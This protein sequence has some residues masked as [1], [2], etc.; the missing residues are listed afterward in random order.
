V[1]T[2][3][4]KNP[5]GS[6]QEQD[7]AS[8][9]TIGR[10]DGNDLILSEGG[11]S[12]KH[13][14]FFL[15]GEDMLVED[16]G[17]ANG[18]WVDGEKIE[19]PTKLS[20]KSQ[21]VI[22]DYEIQLKLGS[23]PLPK[24]S[25]TGARPS[26]EPTAA[27]G[28]ALKPAAPRSTRVV[29]AMKGGAG[30]GGAALAKRPAPQRA[31][32]P[33]L[34]GL[35]GALTGKSFPLSGTLTVG[36]VAGVDLQVE[37]DSVSRR[38]AELE[39]KGREVIVRDLGSA[40]GTSVNGAAI[41]AETVLASG[42]IVQFG[43]VEFMFETGTPSGA[44]APVARP[45]R[46]APPPRRGG[47]ASEVAEASTAET[48]TG[49]GDAKKKRLMLIGGGAVAVL[50]VFVLALA[51][52]PS[53]PPTGPEPIGKGRVK[54][55]P[56]PKDPA[57]QI[58]ELLAECRTYSSAESGLPDW[59]RAQ[60]ACDKVLELEPIH[61]EANALIKRIS[62]LRVCQEN[63]NRGRELASTGDLESALNT[64][65]K[66][67]KDCES[68][69][70]Q[71]L[72][73]ASGPMAELKKR[74]GGDCELYAK[75]S[76]WENAYK[77]CELYSR[78][79]CQSMESKDL[80]PPALMKLKLDGPLN[81]KTDWR[82]SDVKYINFL[83]AKEKLKPNDPMWICPEIPAFRPPPK[84]KDPG[85]Q[86][87]EELA[88]RFPDPDMGKAVIFYFEG[89]FADA[90]VPLQKIKESIG[91]AALHEQATA[92]LLDI[93]NAMNFYENGTSE[94]TNDRPEKAEEHF[95][96]ALLVDEK[97]VLGDKAKT[98]SEDEKRR[99]L[100]R[101]A[102]FVRKNIVETMSSKCLEKGRALADRKDFRAACRIWKLGNGFSRSNIDLLKALTN[103]CTKRASDSF[104]RAETCEQLKAGLDFAVDGDG[105]KEKI[106]ASME[107]QGC[108]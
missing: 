18:T 17:S 98:L 65:A 31:S 104:D 10:A 77:S 41:A 62:I 52:G 39:V 100:D 24:A 40:N 70:L 42:D 76:K 63:F 86:A 33:Q 48:T 29:P 6:Q 79:A 80:Y 51:L 82:P 89:R 16:V 45:G 56:P 2:L 68:Y 28:K 44:R 94:I 57:E 84:A 38:H 59:G 47:R 71:T 97:L 85:L 93:N 105:F 61:V 67:G 7:V 15:E 22:G 78:L 20:S 30:G 25:K 13:A 37:D 95:R 99:E 106:T 19:G 58:E 43:V 26:R 107:E 92:L 75:N 23:K 102:S 36:R 88:K 73:A 66:I 83:R 69:L 8:Q 60:A 101:R 14:R 54:P 74:A 103:V 49:G 32:G 21:V 5:D 55:P 34:R 64:W 4:I 108:N 9:L 50:F 1:A 87:K 35:T 27:A 72:T 12:R 46:D 96:K 90:P 81:P 11:V 53:D 3:V 91:K